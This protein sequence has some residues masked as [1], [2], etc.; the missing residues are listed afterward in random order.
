MGLFFSANELLDIAIGLE[1]QGLAFYQARAELE[2]EPR[3]KEIFRQLAEMERK[4]QRTFEE[5]KG[6]PAG[7]PL[8][9]PPV[10]EYQ[11][12]LKALADSIVSPAESAGAEAARLDPPAALELGLRLEKDSVLL[13]SEMRELV[14]QPHREVLEQI[15]A[16]ER[17]HLKQLTELKKG[18]TETKGEINLSGG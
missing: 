7:F 16:E 6:S 17:A 15:I 5:M 2:G 13:Y 10:E 4:H 8:P 9:Q 12:Y 11:L 1:R 3:T 18:L 14:R